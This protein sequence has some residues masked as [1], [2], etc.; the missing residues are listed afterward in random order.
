MLKPFQMT[1]KTD[2]NHLFAQSNSVSEFLKEIYLEKKD[3][4]P[5]YSISAM[6][7][8]LEISQS[9]LSLVLSGKRNLSSKKLIQV[10]N[11]LKFNTQQTEKLFNIS[12]Y[13]NITNP[14][15]KEALYLEVDKF[16]YIYNWYHLAILDLVTLKSFRPHYAWIAKA[17]GIEQIEVQDAVERLQRLGLLEINEKNEW[18]NTN[19]RLIIPTKNS[20]ASIRNFHL[21]MMKKAMDELSKTSQKDFLRREI[22]GITLTLAPEKLEIAKKR[23]R[24]FKQEMYDL[25]DDEDCKEIYQLNIQFFPLTSLE[26]MENTNENIH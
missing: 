17:L 25:L 18:I 3:K 15:K 26:N 20:K 2:Y 1:K 16:K 8:D 24:Q 9:L 23:I 11:K 21:Q 7:R 5:A 13:E 14:E 10:S 22:S 19:M 6:A 4:N 12:R